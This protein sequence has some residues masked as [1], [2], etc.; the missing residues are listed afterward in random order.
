MEIEEI[1]VIEHLFL[2]CIRRFQWNEKKGWKEERRKKAIIFPTIE[3]KDK[4]K[5]YKKRGK[6]RACNRNKKER[7]G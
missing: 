2:V 5:G 4:R 1:E 7:K 3:K 6:K